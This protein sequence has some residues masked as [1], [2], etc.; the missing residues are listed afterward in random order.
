MTA[1]VVISFFQLTFIPGFILFKFLRIK[2]NT[3][4]KI[5]LYSFAFSLFINYLIVY[6]LTLIGL[7]TPVSVYII[8]TAELI[9]LIFLSIKGRL[10]IEKTI[11]IEI[12]SGL[13]SFILDAIPASLLLVLAGSLYFFFANL[14]SVF[15]HWDAVFSWNRWAIDW[16]LN[17]IPD[18]TYLYPQ[19]IPANWSL[20]YILM[21]DHSL[22]FAAKSIMPLFAVFILFTFY[23]L[24]LVKKNK[25]FILSI[26]FFSALS[27]LYSF[28]YINSGYVDFAVAFFSMA[29]FY[30]ILITDPDDPDSNNIVI[31]LFATAAAVTKQ[32][33]FIILV[34]SVIW[35]IWLMIKN[36]K[37]FSP[38]KTIIKILSYIFVM[39]LG[40]YWYIIKLVD[41]ARGRDFSSLKFLFVDIH[42]DAALIQRLANG[43]ENLRASP[44]FFLI[45]IALSLFS[46]FNRRSRWFTLGITIP[47][48][49]IWGL[50]FSYDDRN[51]IVSFPFL[52]YSASYGMAYLLRILKLVKL[53]EYFVLKFPGLSIRGPALKIKLWPG[54]VL[55][56]LCFLIVLGSIFLVGAF[57]DTIK[58]KQLEKQKTI[59]DIVLNQQIYDYKEEYGIDGKIITDYYWITVL[60]GFEGSSLK[61]FL[62]NDNFVILSNSDSYE[63]V[64]PISLAEE[65]TFGFLISDIYFKH[66]P[67]KS[68]FDSKIR[69]SEYTLVF[70]SS[71]YHFI[72]IN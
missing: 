22:Q 67:F 45:L 31:L 64:D 15:T 44:V 12:P 34:F 25:V 71:G 38:G 5:I 56:L 20:S 43:P 70:S 51:I 42:H 60:P 49:I 24:Y 7:Y 1:F 40:L 21:Q 37:A 68:E 36:R 57:G 52:A 72:R 58:L 29:A 26:F 13:K 19:L 28:P 61:I 69:N 17:D 4:I 6:H 8:L 54:R 11:Y 2:D 16:Y 63:L 55:F 35:L 50:F 47:S 66:P 53:K 9:L 3:P 18:L 32:A 27:L 46:L 41:I 59:G 65:D 48:I 62:E 30:A 23:D 33:G 39:L 14:G 10:K